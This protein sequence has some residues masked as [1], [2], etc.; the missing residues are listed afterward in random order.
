MY[1]RIQ[2][3]DNN[4][5]IFEELYIRYILKTFLLTKNDNK[6]M[7][8]MGDVINI[9]YSIEYNNL[10]KEEKKEINEINN[11]KNNINDKNIDEIINNE[12]YKKRDKLTHL[13]VPI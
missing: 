11:N 1:P 3:N 6:K 4:N 10:F 9:L 12:K 8:I 7:E 13:F 2:K 5:F